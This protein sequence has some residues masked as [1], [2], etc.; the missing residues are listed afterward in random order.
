MSTDVYHTTAEFSANCRP[1]AIATV[2]RVEGSSSAPRGSKG[3]IDEYGK[4]VV[5][6]VDGGCGESAV[7]T[8]ALKCM[9]SGEA[10]DDCARPAG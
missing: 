9:A 10:P 5:G 2:V 3:L 1:F 8:E 7:K 6:W 4:L